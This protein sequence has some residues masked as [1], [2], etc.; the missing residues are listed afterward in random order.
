MEKKHINVE[1]TEDELK[2]IL[3]LLQHELLDIS[4]W[5]YTEYGAELAK[6]ID[7]IRKKLS[8]D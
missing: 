8:L 4:Q 7:K 5:G 2:T 1:F 3:S 6:L